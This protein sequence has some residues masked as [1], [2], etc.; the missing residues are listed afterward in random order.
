MKYHF[1]TKLLPSTGQQLQDFPSC[2]CPLARSPKISQKLKNL[3]LSLSDPKIAGTLW[4]RPQ[5][6]ER[7]IR[8]R[9]FKYPQRQQ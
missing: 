8:G 6:Q 4:R 7:E 9:H 2:F 5:P 3:F 1:K